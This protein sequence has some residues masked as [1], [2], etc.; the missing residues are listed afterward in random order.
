MVIIQR[1]VDNHNSFKRVRERERG[2][3]ITSLK[4]K[5]RA[6]AVKSA[7]YALSIDSYNINQR[8]SK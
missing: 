4:K 5:S 8:A 2:I 6:N 3:V 1:F 7:C